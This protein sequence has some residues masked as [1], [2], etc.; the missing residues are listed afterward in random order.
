VNEPEWLSLSAAEFDVCWEYQKLGETPLM[1]ELPSPGRN[2]EE[3]RHIA[4]QVLESLRGRGLADNAGLRQDIAD[5]MGLLHAFSWSVDLRLIADHLTHAIGAVAGTRGVL[6]A[7]EGDEV[8][9]AS[10]PD[11]AV[12]PNLVALA[13]DTPTGT[14][15]TINVRADVLDAALAAAQGDQHSFADELIRLGEPG[16]DARTLARLWAAGGWCGQFGV[17]VT[18]RA[19]APRRSSR[20]VG[21]F[22]TPDG[23]YLQL[24]RN[25]Y[26]GLMSIVTPADKRKLI[27]S[28]EELLHETRD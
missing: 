1:L 5:Q 11:Y 25:S 22:D 26:T 15:D 20:V 8:Y 19:G 18:D 3:R 6:C 9:L 7:R 4:G 17:T 2:W 14:G 28:V 12:I 24:R 27:T 21:F 23:R 13:G 16:A 10:V